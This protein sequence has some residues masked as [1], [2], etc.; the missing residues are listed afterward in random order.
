MDLEYGGGEYSNLTT[1]KL[2]QQTFR[3]RIQAENPKVP[4][5]KLMMLVAAKWREFTSLG[6]AEEEEE[7]KEDVEEA[8]ARKDEQEQEEAAKED[9]ED[10]EKE[11]PLTAQ[12]RKSRGGRGSYRTSKKVEEDEPEYDDEDDSEDDEDHGDNDEDD[13]YYDEDNSDDDEDDSDYDEDDRCNEEDDNDDNEDDSDDGQK[14]LGRPGRGLPAA[15]K[16]GKGK[17]VPKLKIKLGGRK[18]RG[19]VSDSEE[20]EKPKGDSDQELEDMLLEAEDFMTADDVAA[21]WRQAREEQQLR[22]LALW[23]VK[24]RDVFNIGLQYV[25]GKAVGL[26]AL[27]IQVLKS[28]QVRSI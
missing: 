12:G 28:T 9:E 8:K 27:G 2:F 18:K 14:K 23:G 7:E 21:E 5:S 19:E 22:S 16:K 13:S 26:E 20:E 17:A 15:A 4:M 3:P 11:I 25:D 6:P 24:G 10:D 1:Y